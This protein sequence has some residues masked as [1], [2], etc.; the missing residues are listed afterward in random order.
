MKFAVGILVASLIG[1]GGLRAQSP[2]NSAP[3][4]T[5][6]AEDFSSPLGGGGQVAPSAIRKE[7]FSRLTFGL[8]GSTLGTAAQAATNLGPRLDL[9]VFGNY[10]NFTHN[11]LR[12]GFDIAVNVDMVNTGVKVDYYPLHRFPLRIT[13]GYLFFNQNRLRGDFRARPGASITLNDVDYSSDNA[14]PLHGLGRLH[15]GGSGFMVTTGAGHIVSH[16]RKRF[17]IPFEIGAAFINKP[18]ADFLISG[19]VC[20]SDQS[21]CVPASQFPTFTE[22]V[23]AQLATWNRRVAPFHIYP[24]LE[25]GV[26]YTFILHH[27]EFE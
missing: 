19:R 2:I 15:L 24:I 8:T 16:T 17:T 7:A 12:S 5:Y 22:N 1:C 6:I 18:V 10:L 11:Y 4:L 9:R 21:V 3:R 25:V 23:A 20:A 27:R 26:S 13:P 14:D